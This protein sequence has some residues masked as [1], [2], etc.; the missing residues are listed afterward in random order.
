MIAV[1]NLTMRLS[2]GGHSVTILD[3]VTVEVPEKQMVAITGPSGSGKSKLLGLIAGLDTPTAGSI[4]LDGVENTALPENQM[5]RHRR[6]K[7][8][9]NLQSL[10]MIPNLTA[11]ENV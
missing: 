5:A 7:T 11:L 6:Q 4:R 10:H 3:D 9:Y 2:A 8:G 1:R